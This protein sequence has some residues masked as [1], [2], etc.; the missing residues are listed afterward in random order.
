M[1]YVICAKAASTTRTS[2][3]AWS[4]PVR[5]KRRTSRK[6][7]DAYIL[8]M[9]RLFLCA[10]SR[11]NPTRKLC[12]GAPTAIM[13][14]PPSGR[15]RK[16][17]TS[18]KEWLK[19]CLIESEK[20]E[21]SR[22]ICSNATVFTSNAC[23]VKR[24]LWWSKYAGRSSAK[25][26]APPCASTT[27]LIFFFRKPK[28]SLGWG[29][30][31]SGTVALCAG[32]VVMVFVVLLA[33]PRPRVDGLMRRTL[34]VQRVPPPTRRVQTPRGSGLGSTR[35]RPSK[36][37]ASLAASRVSCAVSPRRAPASL[38]GATRTWATETAAAMMVLAWRGAMTCL[39][40]CVGA[41]GRIIR[42][43]DV[44]GRAGAIAGT[45][46]LCPAANRLSPRAALT[47]N[48]I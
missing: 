23:L 39:Q 4:P 24:S 20:R 34:K 6:L 36:L 13:S 47:A 5:T 33:Y 17:N 8:P 41:V 31:V 46:E 12:C 14:D 32:F 19:D 45:A 21:C 42:V 40:Y 29:F 25:S 48:P 10:S 37:L 11:V 22:S 35:R 28:E 30:H 26:M 18:T 43:E 27:C 16:Q 1:K 38:S 3:N 15:R 44:A 7:S 2:T 9:S